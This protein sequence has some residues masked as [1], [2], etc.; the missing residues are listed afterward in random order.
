MLKELLS[1]QDRAA[2]FT[3]QEDDHCVYVLQYGHQVAVFS[4]QGMTRDSLWAFLVSSRLSSD[5]TVEGEETS[6]NHRR[7]EAKLE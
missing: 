5:G 6:Q 1:D 3:L 2:G 4:S 7:S